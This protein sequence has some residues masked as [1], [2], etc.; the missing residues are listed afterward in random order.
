MFVGGLGSR[1]GHSCMY[2]N[3]TSVTVVIIEL[4]TYGLSSVA[5]HMSPVALVKGLRRHAG[6]VLDFLHMLSYFEINILLYM[7]KYLYRLICM[8]I[9]I[10]IYLSI[11]IHVCVNWSDD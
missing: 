6:L 5:L 2:K 7:Y 1:L 10:Y 4:P 11:Y 9:Y 8:Y 3:N